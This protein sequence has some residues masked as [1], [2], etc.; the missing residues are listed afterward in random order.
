MSCQVK[1]GL[2]TDV[3]LRFLAFIQSKLAEKAVH[4]KCLKASITYEEINIKFHERT[5]CR[6]RCRVFW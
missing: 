6:Y 4:R 1:L 2:L 3:S 5:L